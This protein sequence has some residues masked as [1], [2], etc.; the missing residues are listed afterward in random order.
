MRDFL[1]HLREVN[2]DRWA[3]W[4]GTPQVDALYASNEFG[5]E[6]GEVLNV[7]KK[8]VREDRGWRGSRSSTQALAE[9]IADCIICLDTIARAYGIDIADAIA[10]KFNATSIANDFPHR[11]DV[12]VRVGASS[13]DATGA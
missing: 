1:D 9:E 3:A 10:R 8:L 5:G 13:S 4:A 11:I 6:A 2:A 7:V 12:P